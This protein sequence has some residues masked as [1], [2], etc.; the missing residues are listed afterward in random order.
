MFTV[1]VT[2]IKHGMN[3]VEHYGENVILACQATSQTKFT[4]FV[5]AVCL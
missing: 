2:Q 3:S 1:F 5:A 4:Y